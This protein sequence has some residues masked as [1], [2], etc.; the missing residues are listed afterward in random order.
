MYIKVVDQ[1]S[2]DDFNTQLK[3]GYWVVLYYA[4]WCPHCQTMKPDWNKLSDKF[5]NNKQ[6]NIADVESEFMDKIDQEHKQNVQ[7]FPTI[8][9]C[10]KGKKI[11]DFSGS[12]TYEEMN[13][14]ANDNNTSKQTHRNNNINN[15]L[16][17][18]IKTKKTKKTKQTKQTK[19]TKTKKT[20]S[21]KTRKH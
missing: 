13:K 8:I 17:K 4:N 11:A 7:G 14:F 20:K 16:R 1:K 19:K 2:A 9:S 15:L 12:R 18:I 10:N 3:K 21:K 5:K 6:I